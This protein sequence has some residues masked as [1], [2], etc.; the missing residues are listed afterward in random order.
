MSKVRVAV[1]GCGNVSNKYIPHLKQSPYIDLLAVCDNRID[2]A[3]SHAETY[4]I[5]HYFDDIDKLLAAVKF[6]LLVNLTPMQFHAPYNRKGL[7]AGR[8]V[9]CEKPIA[10]DLSEAHALLDLA[11][12]KGLGLWGAPNSP[13]SPAFQCMASVL[14]SG[15]I[16]RACVAHGI[17]G[18]S[19]P[20][21]PGT[22][23]FYKKGGGSLFDLGVY[24]IT[25]LTGLLGPAKSVVAMAGAAIPERII[26]GETVKVEADDNTALIVDH[27]NAIYSVIQTGFVYGAQREDWTIQVIGT[28]GAMTLGGFDWAPQD[29]SVYSGDRT[30]SPDGQWKIRYQSNYD[31]HWEGGASY[32][33]ECLAKGEK[34]L[35]SGEH[36]V[37]V[38]EIMLAALNS[39]ET[40][41]REQI[42]SSFPWPLGN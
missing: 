28:S 5:A 33:A 4:A 1:V 16:G 6:D 41:R 13:A 17:Y 27:G 22:A 19:G 23:W 30:L 8:N 32:I 11:R 21:W 24:N 3:R 20:S 31:Y 26:A 36:A 2:Y 34:P 14:A 35:L 7:E 18:W 38:L 37:H 12:S 40:G 10:T 42:E 25:T 29:V 39:A 9:W 15:E